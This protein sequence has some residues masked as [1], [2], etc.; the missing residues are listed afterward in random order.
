[1]GSALSTVIYG[2]TDADTMKN[3]IV[4]NDKTVPIPTSTARADRFWSSATAFADADYQEVLEI[5]YA[6][7]GLTNFINFEASIFPQVIALEYVGA[8]SNVWLPVEDATTRAAIQLEIISSS[9]TVLPDPSTVQGHNHPQHDYEGHW[10]TYNL[11]IYPIKIQKLRFVIKRTTYGTAPVSISGAKVPYSV[12]L[13]NI[14]TG[15]VVASEDDIP[16]HLDENDSDTSGQV[17]ANSADVF[18]SNLGF[19][20]KTNYA[21]GLLFNSDSNASLI[22]KS[23][24]QPWSNAVVNFYADVRD[25]NGDAQAIDQ[26]YIDPLYLGP[27]INLYYSNDQVKGPF[28][29]CRKALTSG[30]AT[31]FGSASVQADHRLSLGLYDPTTGIGDQAFVQFNNTL[32][33]FDPSQDW[34]LGIEYERT[35]N[36]DVDTET[37]ILFDAGAFQVGFDQNQYFLM[38]MTGDVNILPNLVPLSQDPIQILAACFQNKMRLAVMQQGQYSYVDIDM[39]MD[40]SPMLTTELFLGCQADQTLMANCY[41]SAFVL[42]Q[43]P[44]TDDLFLTDPWGYSQVPYLA[45][46]EDKSKYNALVRFDATQNTDPNATGFIGGPAFAYENMNWTPIPR[47]YEMQR[48]TM[49]V[50]LTKAKFW[51]L[52]ITNLRPEVNDKFVPVTRQVKLFPPALYQTTTAVTQATNRQS[53]DDLGTNV[54]IGLDGALSF[55]DLPQFVGTGTTTSGVTNTQVYVADDYTTQQRLADTSSAWKYQQFHPDKNAVRFD[56]TG[57]HDYLVQQVTQTTNVSFFAGLRQLRFLRTDKSVPQ[58]RLVFDESFIDDSSISDGNWTSTDYGISSGNGAIDSFARCTSVLL[59]T[60]TSIRG[61]QYATVQT[62]AKMID[63]G[64]NFSDPSYDPSQVTTWQGVGD[65]KVFGLSYDESMQESNLIVSRDSV[66]GYW[67]DIPLNWGED[68]LDIEATA[69]TFGQFSSGIQTVFYSGGVQSQAIS[70]PLGGRIHAA[71]RVTSSS[72][73]SQPL[74]VQVIDANDGAVLAESQS[75]V[76]ENEVKQW[77]ASVDLKDFGATTGREW[78]NLFG[79][80]TYQS[81]ADSF[82]RSASASLGSLDSGQPW[83][84]PTGYSSLTIAGTVPSAYATATNSTSRSQIDT[85]TPWGTMSVVLKNL[86]TTTHAAAVPVLDLGGFY[87]LSD[88]TFSG[89]N[90]SPAEGTLSGTFVAN[91]QYNFK[92]MLT[93]QVPGGQTTGA[94]ATLFPYSIV[95]TTGVLGSDMW[96]QTI[97][98]S[99]AFTTVKGLGGAS[100]QQ[101]GSFAWTPGKSQFD[102]TNLILTQ[103]T[104]P[105]VSDLGDNTYSAVINGRT[106][107]MNGSY[108][109]GS[110]A[111][112]VNN[113][114][115]LRPGFTLLSAPTSPVATPVAS[116]GMFT[117]GT[118]YYKITAL[119]AYGETRPVSVTNVVVATNGLVNL[120]WTAS[121]GAI[122]YNVYRGTTSG[123]ELLLGSSGGLTTFQDLG[124]I[125]DVTPYPSYNSTDGGGTMMVTDVKDQ[126]GTFRFNVTQVAST[127]AANI[128]TLAYLD[129]APDQGQ[130]LTLRADGS[131]WN[132]ITGL[133]VGATTT[134]L[135]PLAGPLEIHYVNTALVST[136]FKTAHPIA[137]STAILIYQNVSGTMTYQGMYTA[138]TTWFSTVRGLG[139]VNGG[140]SAGQYTIMEGFNWNPDGSA[141]A[142]DTSNGTWSQV[143]YADTRTYGQMRN[144]TTGTTTG[145][146]LQIIQKQPTNDTWSVESAT[147]FWDPIVW[148]FSCDNGVTWW[149]A[150]DDVRNNPGGLILFPNGLT[151]Y[152]KL[153]WR[154]NA[155]SPGAVVHSLAIRP[156]YI[157]THGY[158]PPRPSQLP[159]GP[160]LLASEDYGPIERD[161]RWMAWDNPVPHWWWDEG[162]KKANA[163]VQ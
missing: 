56:K 131:I 22:W 98:T 27:R 96:L 155:Y 68:W 88:S 91:T 134:T 21:S 124:D 127:V 113:V 78:K 110:T 31:F 132:D 49:K 65:G 73:L 52:E 75:N 71:A 63:I 76:G 36:Q 42:K 125:T 55:I 17:F 30:A 148:E 28:E 159:D 47:L 13:Q 154:V 61:L 40:T 45:A 79:S 38:T 145:L 102:N 162:L 97:S 123:S 74:W 143:S 8:D 50:P 59:P 43:E 86:I 107:N 119:S 163:G 120:S 101:F 152:N 51:N 141:Y 35:Y 10:Q 114:S 137:N 144:M 7:A 117:A 103:S 94:D 53:D 11:A 70:A 99:R 108:T 87:L 14:E 16:F 146:Q 62:D 41:I 29:S 25:S 4:L 77:Y 58:N 126:Y 106:F 44:W 93:S 1:M 157:G 109:W 118:Y 136:T 5:D 6:S 121:A 2:S 140:T 158:Q 23:E 64:G 147:F 39:S 153:R 24:P 26:I 135:N 80:K 100:G 105:T 116:G 18:G 85:G 150:A 92:F 151:A 90:S 48:G 130:I 156:W 82:Q 161:P 34:W 60:Q 12:A 9:P 54:L 133:Q 15:Y 33:G 115:S 160:N 37:H 83:V 104:A 89:L 142:P 20:K 3:A 122:N 111:P 46:D 138:P 95:I 72:G 84:T 32:L 139:G 112:G 66:N 81:Y 128:T 67:A 149:L 57:T 19:S 129:Y 69:P